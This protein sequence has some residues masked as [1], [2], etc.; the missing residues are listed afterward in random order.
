MI[1]TLTFSAL[2]FATGLAFAQTQPHLSNG[3]TA[4]LPPSA[5]PKHPMLALP[6]AEAPLRLDSTVAYRF[7]SPEDSVKSLKYIPTVTTQGETS[8]QLLNGYEWNATEENWVH[9]TRSEAQSRPTEAPSPSTQVIWH[10]TRG[11]HDPA[12]VQ[13]LWLGDASYNWDKDDSLW[14]GIRKEANVYNEAG[15]LTQLNLF[16]W[17]SYQHQWQDRFYS[18][19]NYTYEEDGTWQGFTSDYWLDDE[20]VEGYVEGQ[21]TYEA[22]GAVTL[23][24]TLLD[25]ATETMEPIAKQHVTYDENDHLASW[26]SYKWDDAKDDWTGEMQIT[27]AYTPSGQLLEATEYVWYAYD[28][29]WAELSQY[30][31]TYHETGERNAVSQYVWD[32]ETEQWALWLKS[33]DYYNAVTSQRNAL[34]TDTWHTYPNPVQGTLNVALPRETY[35]AQVRLFSLTGQ[36]MQQTTLTQP[37]GQLDVRQTP[38]GTYFLELQTEQGRAVRKVV[39]Q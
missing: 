32:Q 6:P 2:S 12:H 13:S 8:T 37:H 20:L 24:Q 35:Q 15:Q 34:T 27:Y 11:Y 5:S 21:V 33:Y 17:N 22:E 14:T 26:T 38:A 19:V 3:R 30:R 10:L 39:I 25:R 1:R 9:Y 16:S 28:S 18:R 7:H 4:D 36:L 23:V 29:V 31:F